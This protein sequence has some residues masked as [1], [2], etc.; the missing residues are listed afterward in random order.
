MFGRRRGGVEYAFDR[1]TGKLVRATGARRGFGRYYCPQCHYTVAKHGGAVQ[2]VHFRHH[3][4]APQSCPLRVASYDAVRRYY[5]EHYLFLASLV[6]DSSGVVLTPTSGSPAVTKPAIPIRHP[7][8]SSPESSSSVGLWRLLAVGLVGCAV[9]GA[10]ILSVIG[11]PLLA[12]SGADSGPAPEVASPASPTPPREPATTRAA[13]VTAAILGEDV[14]WG[15]SLGRL[16]RTL[17]PT[18]ESSE[19]CTSGFTERS[20]VTTR[21]L[22]AGTRAQLM[23]YRTEGLFLI[24]IDLQPGQRA[25]GVLSSRFGT[26]REQGMLRL[27]DVGDTVIQLRARRGRDEL[28]IYERGRR[29]RYHE[30]TLLACPTHR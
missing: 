11:I 2:V 21:G 10:C 15:T 26:P 24:S 18:P 28:R 4:S 19:A 29:S 13:T 6:P 23:S 3:R 16:P 8:G 9:F 5:E 17:R 1:E 14:V 12:G 30:E 7:I 22:F 27:W 25:L 20:N